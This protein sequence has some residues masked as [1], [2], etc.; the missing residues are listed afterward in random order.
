MEEDQVQES[1]EL[2][3]IVVGVDNSECSMTAL[4]WASREAKLRGAALEIVHV[5]QFRSVLDEL[6]PDY[7]RWEQG[8][9]DRAASKAREWEPEV[10]VSGRIA[11]PPAAKALIDRSEGAAML[12]V[13]SR[14][15]GGFKELELGSVSHQCVLHARC[16]VVV[17]RPALESDVSPADAP[18][19]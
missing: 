19:R 3:R 11:D 10:Q 7:A 9:L 6:V 16:P 4:E 12:V 8:R 18:E 1:T 17:I 5:R 2:A 15:L 14:G 13:G